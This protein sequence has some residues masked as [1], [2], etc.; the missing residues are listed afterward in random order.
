MLGRFT[1]VLLG[2]IAACLAAGVTKV[3]FAYTPVELFSLPSDVAADRIARALELSAFAAAHSALFSIP[4][5]LLAIAIAEWRR[6]DA[7]TYF[8]IIGLL[9]AG[10]GF[11]A[12]HQSEAPGGSTVFNIYAV[13]TFLSA[14]VV[15]GLVYW[16]VSGRLAAGP[17]TMLPLNPRASE[18]VEKV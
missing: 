14:G 6:V 17:K 11:V 18:L 7:W 13:S 12:Q 4:F 1:R 15:A 5:A 16:L 3:L 8:A 2:F 10:V 9:I